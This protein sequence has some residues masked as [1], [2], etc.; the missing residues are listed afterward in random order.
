[1]KKGNGNGKKSFSCNTTTT[2]RTAI[3][4]SHQKLKPHRCNNTDNNDNISH[5]LTT[6]KTVESSITKLSSPLPS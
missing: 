3:T 2:E 4:A 6:T 1:M 5:Q